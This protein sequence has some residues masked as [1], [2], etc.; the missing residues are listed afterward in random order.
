[1]SNNHINYGMVMQLIAGNNN[2]NN[3]HDQITN[4]AVSNKMLPFHSN[5]YN[6]NKILEL[7]RDYDAYDPQYIV[8]NLFSNVNSD[9]LFTEDELTNNIC[10]LFNNIRLV[11][12]ISDETVMQFPFSLLHELNPAKIFDNKIYV[13]IPFLS[14]FDKINTRSLYNSC[15]KLTVHSTHEIGNYTDSYSLVTKV[16][17]YSNEENQRL[18]L[19]DTRKLIVQ[20][21]S[22]LVINSPTTPNNNQFQINTTVLNGLTKG[23]LIQC[24]VQELTSIKFYMNN[25]LRFDYNRF[26]ILTACVKISD[27]LLYMPFNDYTNFEEIGYHTFSGAINLSG[28]EN[29]TVC[30]TFFSPQTKIV[31][32]NVYLNNLRC[33][34]GLGGLH[35]NHIPGFIESSTIH[36]PIVPIFGTP[37]NTSMLDMSGNYIN[38]NIIRTNYINSPY[39]NLVASINGRIRGTY[40]ANN[41]GATG[42][43]EHTVE[44]PIPTGYI[45]YLVIDP[46]RSTCNISH[47][48]IIGDQRY[49]TCSSCSN[50]FLETAI[51]QWLR[52][53]SGSQRTCPTCRE[54][55]TNF[56]VYINSPLDAEVYD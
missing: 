37:P 35:I 54:V 34:H 19:N 25:L 56:D 3:H 40:T 29:S 14:L 18:I 45:I 1:M 47:D 11:L 5:N 7:T 43:P 46:N 2:H 36:H 30:L 15:V 44:Y 53:R 17:M 23:F 42:P 24:R 20:I 33:Q 9:G 22:L 4:F 49:M 38:N 39:T 32:H 10:N 28:L 52:N 41:A 21:G 31:I 51:K 6:S 13:C 50:H 27:N 8:I 16:Y 55:W 48:E 12:Q 26:L